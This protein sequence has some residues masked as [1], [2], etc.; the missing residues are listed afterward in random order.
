MSIL[1]KLLPLAAL[2]V[3]GAMNSDVLKENI[4][5]ISKAKSAATSGIEMRGIADAVAA[6]YSETGRLPL[7]NFSQFMK[8]NL[9]EKGGGTS[10]DRSRDMWETHYRI[11]V[12]VQNNGFEI[13]S[14]GPDK[15]WTNEDDLRYV[16]DLTGLGGKKAIE[17][18]QYAQWNALAMA[19]KRQ[20]AAQAAAKE[21][22]EPIDGAGAAKASVAP[23]KSA[24]SSKALEREKKR[25]EWQLSRAESG[26]ASAKMQLAERFM[27]GDNLVEKDLHKAKDYL[28][29]SLN[30]IE[31]SLLRKKVE[32]QLKQVN[33]ELEIEGIPTQ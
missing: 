24:S 5:L 27:K 31:S 9:E 18:S 32:S 2:G 19:Y 21:A 30:G 8:D 17:A 13:W 14:A 26:S 33:A 20:N 7:G 29:Q 16:Y 23:Q 11:V 6:E 12:D 3:V 25:L 15:F 22:G 4:D 10:R 1:T 28:E